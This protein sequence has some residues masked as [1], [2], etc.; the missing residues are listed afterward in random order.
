MTTPDVT[1]LYA[2]IL[3]LIAIYL[4]ATAGARR[5]KEGISLGHG[6]DDELLL[7]MRRHANFVENVPLALVLVALLEMQGVTS[8]AIHG[9]GA[10]LVVGRILHI[11]GFGHDIRN[12]A[13]GLG[14]GLSVLVIA[15]SSIWG[16]V[17]FIGI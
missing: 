16:L 9:L 2:A 17:T 8:T 5:A 6:T 10:A 12:L 1:I 7:R 3:G 14:A 15:V 11:I 13:R 4:G